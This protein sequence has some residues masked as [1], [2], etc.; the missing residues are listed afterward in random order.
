MR[1]LVIDEAA[2]SKISAVCE[3]ADENRID[4][5]ELQAR[6]AIPDGFS[7]IGDDD[8]RWCHLNDGFRCV[9]SIEEQ[10]CGWARHLSI[11]VATNDNKLPHLEAVKLLMPEFGINKSIDD[12]YV[13]IENSSPSSINIICPI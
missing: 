8:N 7:P 11:S 12:C 9:F 10:P 2:K 3:Y 6:V 13:Y 5:K 4:S 1:V